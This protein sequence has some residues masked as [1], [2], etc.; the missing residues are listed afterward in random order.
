LTTIAAG[1]RKAWLW[2]ASDGALIA[3]LFKNHSLT[4]E[5]LFSPD[6]KTLLTVDASNSVQLWSVALGETIG[7]PFRFQRDPGILI[8]SPD[9]KTILMKDADSAPRLWRIPTPVL[10]DPRRIILWAQVLS[11][12]EIREQTNTVEFL[13]VE[14]WRERRH[15]LEAMGGPPTH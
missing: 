14:T 12:M 8:F 4:R 13:D 11:G 10:G 9:G 1:A 7:P 5:P 2:S 6:S 15:R 3:Q